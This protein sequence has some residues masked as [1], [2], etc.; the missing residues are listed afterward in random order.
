M[1]TEGQTETDR[2]G[3]ATGC[4]F[5]RDRYGSVTILST[6]RNLADI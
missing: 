5:V 4:I 6:K 3:E 1:L 2:H